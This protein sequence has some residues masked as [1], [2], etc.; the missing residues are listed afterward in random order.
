MNDRNTPKRDGVALW[1]AIEQSRIDDEVEEILAM[2]DAELDDF[3]RKNG[4]NPEAIRASGVALAKELGERRERN[5][6]HA[7]ANAKL[8]TF[9]KTA[10]ASRTKEKLP[11]PEI[12]RRLEI[13]RNDARF[14]TPVAAL[15]KNK[16]T[17]ASTDEELQ[18]LLDQIELLRKLDEKK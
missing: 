3:I 8:E 11:R 13:A 4:G 12:L 2:S 10:E 18:A 9:R 7:G 1:K 14:A 15:F 6:W 17:E 16:T 5:A